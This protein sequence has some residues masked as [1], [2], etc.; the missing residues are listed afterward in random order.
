M[1]ISMLIVRAVVAELARVDL[2]LPQLL[3]AAGIPAPGMTAPSEGVPVR[4]YARLI[5]GAIRASGDQGLGLTLGARTPPRALHVIS[6]LLLATPTLREAHAALGKYSP[7]LAGALR[8]ELKESADLG[9]FGFSFHCEPDDYSRFAAEYTLSVALNIARDI[10]AQYVPLS[11]VWFAHPRPVYA[12]RYNDVFGCPV[13]FDKPMNALV[14][15][16]ALLDQPHPYADP[17][18]SAI[19]RGAADQLLVEPTLNDNYAQR[20]RQAL[21]Y[22]PDLAH[23][24]FDRLASR[25]GMTRRTLRRRLRDEGKVLSDL[26]DEARFREASKELTRPSESIKEIAE[27]LGYA[28]TSSFHRAFKRWAGVTPSEYRKQHQSAAAE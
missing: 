14:F 24:N 16:R 2:D 23:V 22:E 9:Y 7:A 17:M 21:R 28:E 5:R 11:E 12:P 3:R 4:D 25:W 26:L 15:P 6:H 20:V 13:H 8:F 10:S 1:F 27:R 18:L 19:L